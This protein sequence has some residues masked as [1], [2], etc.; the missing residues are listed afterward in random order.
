MLV[1]T[2]SRADRL[3]K[4]GLETN[5]GFPHIL[6]PKYDFGNRRIFWKST[7]LVIVTMV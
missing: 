4:H 2:K 3:N 5:L 1:A 7:L 6:R